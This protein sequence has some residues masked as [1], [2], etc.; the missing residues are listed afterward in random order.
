[1]FRGCIIAICVC[2]TVLS[3]TAQSAVQKIVDTERAFARMA[4][5]KDTRSAFL[6]YMMDDAWVFSPDATKAKPAW[7][8]RKTPT[9]LL[10]WAPN[11]ADAAVDGSFGYTTGN[12]QWHAKRGD[13][14]TA[15][16]EFNTVWLKQ[17][18]GTYKWLVDIGI[19][20]DK[21]AEYSTKFTPAGP[22]GGRHPSPPDF[23]IRTFDEQA[24]KDAQTAYGTFASE[25]IRM[26]REGKMPFLGAKSAKSVIS[27]TITF[28]EPIEKRRAEDMVFLVR[29]Y[30]IGTE[31]GNQLQV[32][33]YD[34][35]LAG[36]VIV[37]DVLDP[38][39]PK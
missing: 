26:F 18:D 33:K 39:P 4:A 16:G 14:A 21:P 25:D 12:W 31:K 10:E 6:A 24:A 9:A 7:E 17:P 22:T 28:G 36:W 2:A 13:D 29:P 8:A 30:A 38:I 37:L 34:H 32:W 5:D 27:G 23:E 20:H 11:F 1:M 35:K 19:S 3:A 15:F